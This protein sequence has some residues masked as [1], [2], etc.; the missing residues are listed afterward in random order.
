MNNYLTIND[1]I[2]RIR[3]VYRRLD[4]LDAVCKTLQ[5]EKIR[6]IDELDELGDSKPVRPRF[7]THNRS[8]NS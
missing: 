8:H 3:D 4:E 7:A 1:K 5:Y 2:A 6:L